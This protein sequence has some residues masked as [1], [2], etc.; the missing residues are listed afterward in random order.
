MNTEKVMPTAI[1]LLI[2][3]LRSGKYKQTTKCLQDKDG[4]CCLGVAV[5]ISGLTVKKHLNIIL[6]A[7]LPENVKEF[8]NFKTDSGESSK[9]TDHCLMNLNDNE[10]WSFDDI[11]DYLELNW[12]DYLA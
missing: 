5:K 6:G 2:E 9:S 1:K 7:V 3:A 12:Q 10:G 4:Y 11:A 8:Y